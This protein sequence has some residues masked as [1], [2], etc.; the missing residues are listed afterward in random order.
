MAEGKTYVLDNDDA[1]EQVSFEHQL[2][3]GRGVLSHSVMQKSPGF[4]DAALG[5]PRFCST[6]VVDHST[7][8][9]AEQNPDLG[10][11]IT[12]LA[13]KLGESITARLQP[14]QTTTNPQA[15]MHSS[16]VIVPHVNV[17]VHSDAKEPPMF[18]GDASDKY[19]V[20]EWENLVTL[21]LK[22]RSVPVHEHSQEIRA[23]LLGKA[24]DVVR[25]KLRND[26]SIDH[27][28]KP[29]VIFDILKQHF[30]DQT[31]SS[32]PLADFYSTVPVPGENVMDY[33]IRLNKAVDVADEC[34]RRQG[35]SITDAGHEISMMFIKHCPD[36]SLANVFKFKSA[37]KW[38]ASEIQE[39]LDEHMQ[40]LK[41]EAARTPHSGTR[42]H[43]VHSQ[44]QSTVLNNSS[45]S[46]SASSLALP[47]N[48]DNDCMKSLVNL[49]DRLVTQQTQR[50]GNV[51]G[52]MSVPSLSH[53]SCRVC[54]SSDHSTVFHC[55][56]ENR[57]LKCLSPGHW[58]KEC[59]Q[60]NSSGHSQ[61]TD[62]VDT[63]AQHLN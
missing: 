50:T 44:C 34:L 54:Q 23:R 45:D 46:S 26:P 5:T 4:K 7:P 43:E 14:P 16:D 19:T 57:C 62:V 12:Q 25:V 20:H 48:A 30:S 17:V 58:K 9:R 55:R 39:R 52:H 36:R 6:R 41:A 15:S 53:R 24:G 18:R 13:E 38:T 42:V 51:P 27:A 47:V 22:K 35:R 59:P 29:H 11:L 32:M 33:W 1:S 40:T 2:G 31:Y 10:A 3:V 8:S 63:Q 49:L 21:Y 28:G 61:S 37:E 60:R 56:R